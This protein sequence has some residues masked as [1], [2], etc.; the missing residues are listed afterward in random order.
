MQMQI[1]VFTL[2]FIL[3][4]I[5]IIARIIMPLRSLK[6]GQYDKAISEYEKLLKNSHNWKTKNQFIYNIANCLHIKGE[7]NDSIT[8][9]ESMNFEKF[10]KNIKGVY[11]ALYAANL[12]NLKSDLEKAEKY[13]LKSMELIQLPINCLCMSNIEISRGNLDSASNYIEEYFK[14]KNQSKVSWGFITTLITDRA[15]E[16]TINSYFLG[17]YYLQIG[18]F[19]HAKDYLKKSSDY[20]YE[21]YYAKMSKELLI[22]L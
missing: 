22:T 9:L 7:F 21:N 20:I 1:L 17:I 14:L 12:L 8:Y 15:I 2:L 11:Y 5:I 10:D 4:I 13:F 18:D 6:H 16:E 19:V 3:F